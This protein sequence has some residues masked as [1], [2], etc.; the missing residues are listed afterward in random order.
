M[1]RVEE[2]SG[3]YFPPPIPPG[4]RAPPAPLAG[5]P[6]VE[7][8]EGDW[9]AAGSMGRSV[10]GPLPSK[11]GGVITIFNRDRLYGPPKERLLHLYRSNR[12]HI[13]GQN[14][15]V[16]AHVT[17]GVGGAQNEFFCD[18]GGHVPLVC[19][20]IRVDAVSYRPFNDAAFPYVASQNLVTN[21][22][23]LLGNVGSSPSLPPTLTTDVQQLNNAP[24]TINYELPD[25]ARKVVLNLTEFPIVPA[26]GIDFRL[27]FNQQGFQGK[28][29]AASAELYEN[30]ILI[31]GW[32][33]SIT[34]VNASG[35]GTRVSLTYIL[36]L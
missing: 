20:S 27:I 2:L 8:Q 13:T 19:D 36:G 17:Y 28:I 29:I 33:D 23:A 16:Y 3:G 6:V 5:M 18:W 10:L 32:C 1:I 24:S 4:F 22:G 21:F 34:V 12:I 25:F 14:S 11:E 31:P 15:D 9:T 7:P 26:A 30:G 35:N